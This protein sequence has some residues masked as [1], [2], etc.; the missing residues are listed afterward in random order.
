MG[1]FGLSTPRQRRHSC[2]RWNNHTASCYA[3]RSP[4]THPSRAGATEQDGLGAVHLAAE[5]TKAQLRHCQ[6]MATSPTAGET[7]MVLALARSA[8]RWV[9]SRQPVN[10]LSQDHVQ[11]FEPLDS[12]APA[13]AHLLG[14]LRRAGYLLGLDWLHKQ[15][16]CDDITVLEAAG[17]KRGRK[18]MELQEW[19]RGNGVLW[20]SK[21][22]RADGRTPRRRYIAE[23]RAASGA[24]EA[25]L[26]R[27]LFGPGRSE[28]GPTR[29]VV[30]QRLKRG[31]RSVSVAGYGEVRPSSG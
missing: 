18:L 16:A 29:R 5:V 21:L 11:L 8:Q 1:L 7:D 26:K 6:E 15:P 17:E 23:L 28:A 22:L 30:R 2:S 4:A 27:V 20:V 9:G 19:R 3:T 10:V 31:R 24:D 25:R 12:S 14:E 13:G